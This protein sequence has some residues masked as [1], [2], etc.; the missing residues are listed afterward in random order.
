MKAP[1]WANGSCG[2]RLL[3][4]RGSWTTSSS[5]AEGPSSRAGLGAAKAGGEE[6]P[7]QSG[8]TGTPSGGER[9][10]PHLPTVRNRSLFPWDTEPPPPPGA[11]SVQ[12]SLPPQPPSEDKPTGRLT[13]RKNTQAEAGWRRRATSSLKRH[14]GKRIFRCGLS[15][16][17]ACSAPTAHSAL[18][19]K[20]PEKDVPSANPDTCP[21]TPSLAPGGSWPRIPVGTGICR[22][23]GGQGTG[24]GAGFWNAG[25]CASGQQCGS[26]AQT[27]AG[28]ELTRMGLPL[29]PQPA[30]AFRRGTCDLLIVQL[31]EPR[32]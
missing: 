30:P 9:G 16:R 14:P 21:R 5:H 15:G 24:V 25:S 23:R 8:L 12:T 19:S 10:S 4:L 11:R 31:S 29:L 1:H 2:D 26:G 7:R 6:T 32:G 13:P 22:C 3:R 28:L 18:R 27:H 20:G 17:G